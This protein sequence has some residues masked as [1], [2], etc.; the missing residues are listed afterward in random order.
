MIS[1]V[2]A[3][4]SVLNH[5][6]DYRSKPPLSTAHKTQERRFL[7]ALAFYDRQAEEAK[8]PRPYWPVCGLG[9]GAPDPR[10]GTY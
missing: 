6:L 9:C 1:L 7:R 3:G 4:S 2:C 10:P 8:P 5:L